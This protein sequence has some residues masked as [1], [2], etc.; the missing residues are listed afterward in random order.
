MD[1]RRRAVVGGQQ[2]EAWSIEQRAW[3]R[4]KTEAGRHCSVVGTRWSVKKKQRAEGR[5]KT[6]VRDQRKEDNGV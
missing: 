3:G 1:G 6:E 4:G 2:E 5:R